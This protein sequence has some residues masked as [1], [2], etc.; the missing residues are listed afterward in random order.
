MVSPS[1]SRAGA[2]SRADALIIGDGIIGL[3]IAYALADAGAECTVIGR[4]SDGTASFAAAGLLMPSLA[5]L[6]PDVQPFFAA[7]LA[8]YPAFV[9]RLRRFDPELHLVEGLYELDSGASDSP[10]FHPRD[11]SIDNVRLVRALRAAVASAGVMI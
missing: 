7:S 8:A 2:G 4:S 5:S 6:A 11:G 3:S 9:E 1:P 10:R